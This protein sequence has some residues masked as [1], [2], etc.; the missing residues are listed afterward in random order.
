[1]VAWASVGCGENSP[2]KES[3]IIV[4]FLGIAFGCYGLSN[5][6][7]RGS[8]FLAHHRSIYC[9]LVSF[10]VNEAVVVGFDAVCRKSSKNIVIYICIELI[11]L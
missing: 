9:D 3:R 11:E 7:N 1:M 2:F 6:Q 5:L 8:D 4:Y 10:V